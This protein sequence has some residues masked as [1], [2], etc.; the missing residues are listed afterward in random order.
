MIFYGGN[1]ASL[2]TALHTKL[3]WTNPLY[4]GTFQNSDASFQI[5]ASGNVNCGVLTC[6]NVTCPDVKYN[7]GANSLITSLSTI[8]TFINNYTT[9]ISNLAPMDSGNSIRAGNLTA[10]QGVTCAG[11]TVNGGAAIAG[12]IT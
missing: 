4:N 12:D 3:N 10:I 8:N 6:G 9:A 7:F 2:I 5:G 1:N 11:L